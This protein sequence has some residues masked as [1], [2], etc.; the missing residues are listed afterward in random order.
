[1]YINFVRDSPTSSKTPSLH[2]KMQKKALDYT[3][4]NS[5]LLLLSGIIVI[6]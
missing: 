6:L 1:M 5:V 2:Q 3:Y 4:L